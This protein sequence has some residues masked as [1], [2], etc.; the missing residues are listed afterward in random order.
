MRLQINKYGLDLKEDVKYPDARKGHTDNFSSELNMFVGVYYCKHC[1]GESF[2]LWKWVSKANSSKNDGPYA[3]NKYKNCISEINGFCQ[4]DRCPICGAKL[5]KSP[6][7]YMQMRNFYTND[8]L[9]I[10]ELNNIDDED[11]EVYEVSWSDDDIRHE[12]STLAGNKEFRSAFKWFNYKGY[13]KLSDREINEN[14]NIIINALSNRMAERRIG[15]DERDADKMCKEFLQAK[16][17][18]MTFTPSSVAD[19]SLITKSPEE[20]K[21]YIQN[22]INIE[23]NIYSLEKRL[24]SL[25]CQRIINDRNLYSKICSSKYEKGEKLEDEL[26]SAEEL[27]KERLDKLNSIQ[28]RAICVSVKFPTFPVKPRYKTL[29][30]CEHFADFP[31]MPVEPIL[32]KTG[33]FNK[34]K[35]IAENNTLMEQYEF[36]L[37]EYNK[38]LDDYK[39][40]LEVENE[41][42]KA[43]YEQSLLAYEEKQKLCLEE[44]KRLKEEKEKEKEK[45]T[46]IAREELKEAEDR[47]NSIRAEME[48]FNGKKNESIDLSSPLPCPEYATKVILDKEIDDAEDTLSK[49]IEAKYK[50]YNIGVI[51]GKYRDIVALSTFYEYLM[52][53]RCTALDGPNGAYNLYESECRANMII[54]QLSKVIELLEEIK[55]NQYMICDILQSISFSLDQLNHTMDKTLDSIRNIESNTADTNAYLDYIAQNSDVIAHNTA[56]TA[57]YSKVNAELT[58]SLGYLIALS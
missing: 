52:S 44:E 38:A 32:K 47:I 37:C 7:H 40:K 6:G 23:A 15:L 33:L 2:G 54:S 41:K 10:E 29:E 35:T 24:G 42:L 26:K 25:Y 13:S 34:A 55:H 57:Y 5:I 28:S 53:G 49:L 14:E 58:N 9:E 31:K 27:Y 30:D 36:A 17:S 21:K 56:V 39:I 51:F 12:F 1:G 16:N 48:T 20:L 46:N 43:N 3:K 50:Y 11:D 45:E 18:V 8:L 19:V 22:L 4:M